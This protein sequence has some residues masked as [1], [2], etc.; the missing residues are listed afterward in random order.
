MRITT[1]GPAALVRSQITP[2]PFRTRA[3]TRQR[4]PPTDTR[5]SP[6]RDL[7]TRPCECRGRCKDYDIPL[8]DRHLDRLAFRVEHWLLSA[9]IDLAT[10]RLGRA[11]RK[12]E[13]RIIAPCDH[14]PATG[15]TILGFQLSCWEEAK[16]L[17]GVPIK[18]SIASYASAGTSRFS[19]ADPFSS[20]ATTTRASR[21]ATCR[22]AWRS[23]FRRSRGRFWSTAGIV[24]G[25]TTERAATPGALR[26]GR[27]RIAPAPRRQ[28]G[29]GRRRRRA[30]YAVG[31]PG[32]R[33]GA[34]P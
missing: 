16:V 1:A 14:Q 30:D 24:R 34:L 31:A 28:R 21:R 2:G 3:S 7:A 18:R 9:P 10:G 5:R 17:A 6:L 29:R 11:I 23:A 26:P 27:P 12:D 25:R 4:P 20:R 8:S 15:V 33:R 22:P 13:Q 32:A 19:T